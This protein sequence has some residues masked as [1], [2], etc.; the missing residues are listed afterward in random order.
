MKPE[1]CLV[2]DEPNSASTW[3]G[4]FVSVKL[5]V[6]KSFVPLDASV[7]I[8]D[9]QSHVCDGRQVRHGNP[10]VKDME[11]DLPGHSGL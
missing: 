10:L 6:E 7:E 2:F 11:S 9:S 8:A 5:H 1:E 3:T 4:T